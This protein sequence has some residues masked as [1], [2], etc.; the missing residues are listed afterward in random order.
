MCLSSQT[1][2]LF[3]LILNSK[4]MN[5]KRL[6]CIFLL[7]A[8]L[9]AGAAP[10]K[11]KSELKAAV[12][13]LQNSAARAQNV[14]K[15]NCGPE[16]L[17]SN[18]VSAVAEQII[19]TDCDVLGLVDVCDSIAGRVGYAGL[20][21]AL[22]A[23]KAGY[24]WLALSNARPSLPFEGAYSKTQAIIW[25][26]EKYDCIDYG[27]NWLGGYFDKNRIRNDLKDVKG[28]AA[29]SVT[30]AK[31]REKATGKMFYF[32]VASTNGAS[33]K[34]LNTVNCENLIKIADEIVVTDGLPSV[35]AGCFSMNDKTPGYVDHLAASRWVDVYDRLKLDGMLLESEIKTNHT[36]NNT[37]GDKLAGGRPD[38]IFTDGFD[39]TFYMVGRNRYSSSNGEAV[40]PSSGFPV[41]T[42]LKF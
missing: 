27:I 31:F 33:S 3:V 20:P 10:K 34:I 1:T 40:Y 42:Y 28:D 5:M 22:D 17:W 35:I 2:I 16:R 23:K 7:L 4:Y 14:Q 21:Q 24:S 39:V 12:Y 6:I 41:I 36:R 30:W 13:Y 18:C 9:V 26:T 11:A 32:M 8:P 37:R 29:K 38:Y 15:G 19:A 25:R